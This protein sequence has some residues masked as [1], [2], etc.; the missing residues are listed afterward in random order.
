MPNFFSRL[1]LL[2]FSMFILS[3]CSPEEDK[4][5]KEV[6]VVVIFFDA[7]YNQKDLNKVL[8][9]SSIKLQQ[10][11][12]KYRTLSNFSRR[13]LQLSFD[14]VTIATQKSAIQVIDNYNEQ[15]TITVMLTGPRNDRV[16]KDVRR[17]NVIK[18]GNIWLV[19]EILAD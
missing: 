12:K 1:F 3:G 11:I 18:Q 7:I 16:Y 9:V 10:K 8:A 6:D 15:A 4:T 5:A 14:S 2:I 19:D 13:L 17:V